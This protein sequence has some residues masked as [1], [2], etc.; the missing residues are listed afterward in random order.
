[1][2]F[3]VKKL[4]E[5]DY[6]T[7]FPDIARAVAVQPA[8]GH[9]EVIRRDG[10]LVKIM[11]KKPQMAWCSQLSRASLAHGLQQAGSAFTSI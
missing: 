9:Q 1:V 4:V 10:L 6:G 5:D 2:N 3:R 8:R 11:L 7:R